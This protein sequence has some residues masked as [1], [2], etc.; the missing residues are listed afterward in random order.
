MDEY[1]LEL[2]WQDIPVGKENAITYAEL[3]C[4]WDETERAVRMVLHKLG[5]YDNGYNYVLIRSARSKGFYK[6][7]D[8][9][10]IR[11]YRQE[12]LNKG[13]SMFSPFKKINRVINA[14][15]QQ[16]EIHNNMRLVREA[17]GLKQSDVCRELKNYDRAIDKSMLSKMENGVCLPTPY[18]LQIMAKI[19]GCQPYELVN[20]DLYY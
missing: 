12:V 9:I 7:D 11:K 13:R 19:Y 6:T 3:M 5:S 4:K 10:E 14:N 17:K 18:Q 16:F 8:L 20:G 15:S 1:K 2:Y